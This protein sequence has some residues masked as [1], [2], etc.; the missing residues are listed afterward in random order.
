MQE[1]YNEK[2]GSFN[3]G[4]STIGVMIK[5]L[6]GVLITLV[7]AISNLANQDLFLS[8]MYQGSFLYRLIIGLIMTMAIGAVW[9]V[10]YRSLYKDKG[11]I[12]NLAVFLICAILAGQFMGNALIFAVYFIDYY[13]GGISTTLVNQALVIT[14][15][16]TIISVV[17]AI[18]LLPMLKE[19]QKFISFG[20]NI[21]KITAVLALSSFIIWIVGMILAIFSIDFVLNYYYALFYGMGPIAFIFNILAIFVA[22][23]FLMATIATV[24]YEI[25]IGNPKHL[26]YAYAMSLINAIVKVYVEI[27]KLVLRVLASQDQD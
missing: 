15:M 18:I 26:E 27:F 25:R 3:K 5:T 9:M 17:G 8:F 1:V 11:A 23:F 4:A 7:I 2:I 10:L 16:A 6:L 21:L 24:K 22:E 19:N 20:Q 12:L 13:A 14:F